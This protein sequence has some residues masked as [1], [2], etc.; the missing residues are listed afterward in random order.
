[1]LCHPYLVSKGGGERVVVKIAERFDAPIYVCVY[2]KKKLWAEYRDL[3][4]RV[5]KTFKPTFFG[6]RWSFG[7]L[8]LDAD[9]VVPVGH[10]AQWAA[11]KNKP[12][13]WYCCFPPYIKTGMMKYPVLPGMKWAEKKVIDKL[14]FVFSDSEFIKGKLW[15][16]YKKDSE[17]LYPACDVEKYYCKKYAPYFLYHS[18]I[19]PRKRF[20]YA[21]K[22]MHIVRKKYPDFTLKIS[23]FLADREYIARLKSELGDAGKIIENPSDKDLYELFANAYACL[24]SPMI[25]DFGIVPTEYMSASKAVVAVNEGGPKETVVNGKTGFLVNSVEEMAKRMIQL[26]EDPAL[27]KKMGKAGRKRAEKNYSWDMFLKR[28]GEVYEELKQG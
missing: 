24:Y 18:S 21:I 7:G 9:V 12:T 11:I 15:E 27:S 17:V 6:Y 13:L 5:I 14:D 25:E 16:Y 8:K 4:V 3:D 19:H 23:G 2:D 26:I 22:A 20:E 1:M 10:P 28:F